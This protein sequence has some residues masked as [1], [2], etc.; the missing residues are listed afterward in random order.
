M[1]TLIQQYLACELRHKESVLSHCVIALSS[2]FLLQLGSDDFVAQDK[3]MLALVGFISLYLMS[4]V[5]LSMNYR[6]QQNQFEKALQ[7]FS[8][9]KHAL[10][11][12]KISVQYVLTLIPMLVVIMLLVLQGYQFNMSLAVL[13]L[14]AL[15]FMS[16]LSQIVASLL[17][18][19][20]E[21]NAALPLLL[22]PMCIPSLLYLYA[23]AVKA[24][25]ES[26][27]Q[28][29]LTLLGMIFIALAAGQLFLK[30]LWED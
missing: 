15:L 5:S 1:W 12:A 14:L 7:H 29:L 16:I 11:Y 19:L 27:A 18:Y 9:F 25:S 8:P 17:A 21:R 30:M 3:K 13:F 20:P 6:Y 22:F 4:Y 10:F 23:V 2:Y 28:P 24:Y 26:I